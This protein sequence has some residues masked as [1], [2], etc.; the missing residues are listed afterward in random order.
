MRDFYT[1]KYLYG[2]GKGDCVDLPRNQEI[3]CG[4]GWH[5]T[6]Y[7]NAVTFGESREN[8]VI[9]SAEI[10][11]EDVLSVYSKVRVKK[12]SNVQIVKL[13]DKEIE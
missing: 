9:I 3:E 13:S 12:F 8:Y 11:L 6:N 2:I 1:G 10:A 7:W 5:F 4:E